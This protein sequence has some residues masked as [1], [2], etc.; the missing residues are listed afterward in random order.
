MNLQK[1]IQNY[2]KLASVCKEFEDKVNFYDLYQDAF[3]L[4]P[5]SKE[6]LKRARLYFQREWGINLDSYEKKHADYPDDFKV[7]AFDYC[8]LNGAAFQISKETYGFYA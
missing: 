4:T 6:E 5:E 7:I 2:W 1:K 3:E 8:I